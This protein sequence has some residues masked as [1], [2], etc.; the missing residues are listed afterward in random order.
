MKRHAFTLIELMA[1]VVITGI[2]AGVIMPTISV[3]LGRHADAVAE[4]ERTERSVYAL[5]RMLGIVRELPVNEDGT[6]AVDNASVTALVPT[7]GGGFEAA[8][9]VLYLRDPVGDRLVLIDAIDSL[10]IAYRGA[11]G[12]ACDAADAW[13]IDITLTIDGEPIAVAGFVRERIGG[14]S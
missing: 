5:D 6:L 14:P 11:D 1:V 3:A 10:A 12:L 9:G 7:A 4:R 8:G 2:V 13:V